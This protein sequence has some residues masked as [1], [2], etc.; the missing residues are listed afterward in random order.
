MTYLVHQTF[1]PANSLLFVDDFVVFVACSYSTLLSDFCIVR[2]CDHGIS[3]HLNN[4]DIQTV[5]KNKFLRLT[6]EK[7]LSCL[8]KLNLLTN[9]QY[10]CTEYVYHFF[11]ISTEY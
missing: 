9:C 2:N 3:I 4:T 6:F 1:R 10:P 8:C 7:K 5:E 11:S